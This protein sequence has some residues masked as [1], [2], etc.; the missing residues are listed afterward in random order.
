MTTLVTG[1]TGFLGRWLVRRLIDDGDDVRVLSRSYDADL[2]T[3]G[4]E[5]VE[6]S[7]TDDEDVRRA[8]DG[9]ERCYHLAGRVER[10]RSRSHEMYALHVGGTRRLLRAAADEGV[11]KVVVASTSGTVGVGEHPDFVGHDDSPY[12]ERVVR[13][14]P[15]YLSKIYAEKACDQIA[16]ETG[17]SIVQMR[18]TLLLGP[19]DHRQSSTGDVVLFMQGAVPSL[20]PGGLSFVDVRDV[21]DAFVAA[22]EQAPP[23]SKYLLGAANM[24]LERFFEHLEDLTGVPAPSLRLSESMAVTGARLLGAAM[25]LAG[26]EVDLDPAS[27]EMAGRYWYIDWSRAEHDLGFAPRDPIV[28][29]RDTVR[30]I[31]RHHPEFASNRDAPPDEWVRPETIEW[32]SKN[33]REP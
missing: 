13:N 7:I 26:K 8:L 12:A 28:T 25:R 27:V 1:G 29:L 5:L 18:P 20:L 24:S 14:W 21:A 2:E 17:L 30:W 6:G 15:Y 32:T 11:D 22:M 31:R 4:I 9:V 3:L 10:D 19:G 16:E 33:P 23:G